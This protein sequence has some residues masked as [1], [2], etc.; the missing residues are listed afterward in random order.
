MR[1]VDHFPLSSDHEARSAIFE[2]LPE[3]D[4]VKSSQTSKHQHDQSSSWLSGAHGSIRL[5][6]WGNHSFPQDSYTSTSTK[7]LITHLHSEQDSKFHNEYR[8]HSKM[9]R[10]ARAVT[11]TLPWVLHFQISPPRME[12]CLL[13]FCHFLIMRRLAAIR[14]EEL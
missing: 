8:T 14:A 7:R 9:L 4:M 10:W 11:C 6:V 13:F 3:A 1:C 2:E 5:G 12:P